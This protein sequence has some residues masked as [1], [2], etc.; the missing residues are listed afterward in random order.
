VAKK[1]SEDEKPNR[2]HLKDR[3]VIMIVKLKVSVGL[4]YYV[5]NL[6]DLVEGGDFEVSEG[7][8]VGGFLEMINWPQKVAAITLVNGLRADKDKVLN[9]SDQI[10]LL[11][12]ITGG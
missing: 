3:K 2:R 12:P 5:P 11:Q 9:E 1:E 7:A 4:R 6:D 10:Y 8:T